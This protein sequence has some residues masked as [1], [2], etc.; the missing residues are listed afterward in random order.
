MY[1]LDFLQHG[2]HSIHGLL[3]QQIWAKAVA[4]GQLQ[5]ATEAVCHAVAQRLQIVSSLQYC[6]LRVRAC[7]D[8]R[9]VPAWCEIKA[10]LRTA[11]QEGNISVRFPDLGVDC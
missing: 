6:E 4:A 10:V 11:T 5:Q 3:P 1:G 9:R 8:I 7:I 2:L